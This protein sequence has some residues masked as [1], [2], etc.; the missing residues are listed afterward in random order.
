MEEKLVNIEMDNS[1]KIITPEM[2]HD[3]DIINGMRKR[4]P[5]LNMFGIEGLDSSGKDTCSRMIMSKIIS[6]G[7]KMLWTDKSVTPIIFKESFPRYNT[8]YGAMIKDELH[9][10]PQE[11]RD[12]I[13]M[14][15]LYV[16]DRIDYFKSIMNPVTMKGFESPA[17]IITDRSP[18]ANLVC[19]LHTLSVSEQNK[20]LD[21]ALTEIYTYGYNQI[22]L[23]S[24]LT[25]AGAAKHNEFMAKD[26]GDRVVD[27]NEGKEKQIQF[28]QN[29]RKLMKIKEFEDIIT[30]IDIDESAINTEIIFADI[31]KRFKKS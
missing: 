24:R 27:Y 22:Y 1:K 6:C 26:K 4:I 23:F 18:I 15:K 25:P 31:V 21:S 20:L 13:N 3:M 12:N 28:S 8:T 9:N 11:D 30:F 14:S 17:L 5:V 29:I 7:K 19:N 2:M 10:T 16:L